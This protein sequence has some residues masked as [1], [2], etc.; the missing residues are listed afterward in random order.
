MID[1]VKEKSNEMWFCAYKKLNS[2]HK[3]QLQQKQSKKKTREKRENY[4]HTRKRAHTHTYALHQR[5]IFMNSARHDSLSVPPFR[6]LSLLL[7]L[8]VSFTRCC[9]ALFLV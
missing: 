7:A 2:K 9:F 8:A 1:L 6:S 3:Q 5:P 4:E